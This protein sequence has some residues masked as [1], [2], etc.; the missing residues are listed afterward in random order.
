[1]GT[2]MTLGLKLWTDTVVKGFLSA[3]ESNNIDAVR[4]LLEHNV[5]VDCTLSEDC[6]T[7]LHIAS[8]A[9]Y[10]EIVLLLLQHDANIEANDSRQRTP[11]YASAVTGQ[12]DVARVLIEAG[13]NVKATDTYGRGALYRAAKRGYVDICTL[14]LDKDSSILE[15]ASNEGMPSVGSSVL[16]LSIPPLNAL[17]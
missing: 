17:Y 6:L 3:V 16:T 10:V 5:D 14:L 7:G 1:M 11:L 8:E 15:M 9:G 13:A 2:G 4:T 12:F